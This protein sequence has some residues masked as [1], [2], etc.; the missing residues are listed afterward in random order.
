VQ[1][2]DVSPEQLAD[3]AMRFFLAVLQGPGAWLQV[4]ADLDLSLTQL[5]ALYRLGDA[6][7]R[8]VSE[9]AADLSLS[10]AATSRAVDGLVQRDL[11]ERR[12]SAEDR[13]AR[14]VRLSPTGRNTLRRVY[15]TRREDLVTALGSLSP[16]ER[17]SLHVAFAPVVERTR[18]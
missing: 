9:L 5:K 14:R 6:D 3:E 15:E 4:I 17:E 18:P 1:S 10:M 12:E 11:A 8:T 16:Q 2:I 13:R 7:E